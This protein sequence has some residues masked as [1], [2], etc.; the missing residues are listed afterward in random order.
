MFPMT[1]G[2]FRWFG[3]LLLGFMLAGCGGGGGGGGFGGT[4]T[5]KI[6]ITADK[7]VLP[8]NLL[9]RG[10][11]PSGPFTNTITV[12]V[13]KNDRL[14]AAP[15]IAID[16]VSGL[17]SG[18]LYYLDGDPEHEEC[19]ATP[20]QTCPPVATTPLA[21]RRLV[22]EDT[23]GTV[24]GHFHVGD[25]PGTVVLR[26]SAQDPATGETVVADLAINIGPGV[27]TGQP[28]LV[29]FEIVPSPLYITGQGREDV[30]R[31]QVVVLDDAGQPV[32]NP[33]GNNLRLQ[34]LP[35]R[36]NGGEK[37]AAI[38]A[39]GGTE[40]GDIV[41][42]RTIN[43]RAEIALHSGDK[44][45]TVAITAIADRADNNIDNGI[46][47]SVSDIDTIPI[48]SGEIAS[49]TFTGPYP[50][51]VIARSNTLVLGNGDSIDATGAVYTRAISVLAV[52]EF[53]N[54]PPP[55]EFIT[56]R[57]M[58]GPLTGYPDLG[59]GAFTIAAKDGNPQEGGNTFTTPPGGSSLLGGHTNCQLVLEGGAGQ[60]GGWLINGQ[61]QRNLLAVFNTFNLV[62]DTGFT[63]PYTVGCPPYTGNVANNVN[64]ITVFTDED[65][66]ATTTINY[67]RTQLGRC[68]K[69][70]AE[71]NDGR[72]GAVMGKERLGSALFGDECTSW[73]L[74]VP[75]GATL[76][77]IPASDQN[78]Q[79][80]V[81]GALTDRNIQIQLLDGATPPGPLPG[82]KLSVQVVITD[83]DKDAAVAAKN[84]LA[85]AQAT[86]NAISAS[87]PAGCS[88]TEPGEDDPPEDTR[89]ASWRTALIAAQDALD[90]A[91]ADLAVADARDALH[92]PTASF[93]P[94]PLVTGVDGIATL[95]I[96]VSDLYTAVSTGGTGDAKVE[97]IITT[98]GPEIRAETLT[99]TVL[100]QGAA[101]P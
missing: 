29:G 88:T 81:G 91:Q 47:N 69:L 54:P 42:T 43:G 21:F 95:N 75:T 55:G 56:F 2:I 31:F 76:V 37:L 71:A 50:G 44:P 36:P 24:T 82:E 8:A 14:F 22:F 98:V 51:A 96:S 46:A 99:I 19:L 7:T 10:P 49:L 62:D 5:L 35:S 93:T 77:V 74:G 16:V 9:G 83:P 12:Q 65:G 59:H 90:K 40:E 70:T 61:A 52:D 13:K 97:F 68:F 87:N 48:G 85:T 57:L 66:I 89:C 28:A 101:A 27:S 33:A 6:S 84:A 60:E 3:L 78:I 4:D 94:N 64:G 86:F 38:N 72:V 80:P 73:Y 67:P 63:V 53:G 26:A 1:S 45:G 25:T 34:L 100:P 32:P 58:D 18:A 79:V 41:N 30:K 15:N 11:D 23:T 39:A 20:P 17:A 92:E